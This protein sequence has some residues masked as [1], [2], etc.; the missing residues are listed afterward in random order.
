MKKKL[1][2][3]IVVICTLNLL[4]I[5]ALADESAPQSCGYD[6]Q[7]TQMLKAKGDQRADRA[8]EIIESMLEHATDACVN[9]YGAAACNVQPG[10]KE[11]VANRANPNPSGLDK[12]E[13]T[14]KNV[15][16][17]LPTALPRM[18]KD[19]GRCL[20]VVPSEKT[21]DFL[22][23]FFA[24]LEYG[25]GV[26]FCR[27][28]ENSPFDFSKPTSY[29]QIEGGSFGPNFG[30]GEESDVVLSVSKDDP[31]VRKI[32]A[33]GKLTATAIVGRD[34]E[35]G[36]QIGVDKSHEPAIAVAYSH[37]KGFLFAANIDLK[38]ISPDK[39]M[40]EAESGQIAHERNPLMRWLHM[41]ARKKA[42]AACLQKD[43]NVADVSSEQSPDLE[44]TTMDEVLPEQPL[45]SA[46]ASAMASVSVESNKAVAEAAP[47]A[48]LV[49]GA[50]A[51]HAGS[52]MESQFGNYP[53]IGLNY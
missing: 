34:L 25:R 45:Q 41:G 21:L 53:S 24:G 36:G 43:P 6:Y 30:L 9:E 16:A 49:P 22:V 44:S 20:I 3:S 2:L 39:D 33:A 19:P 52:T 28:D 4:A 40:N 48:S 31:N 1:G 5:S 18:L 29:V 50:P 37:T 17:M 35:V 32:N 46:P 12:F 38:S 8:K 47:A 7:R 51:G 11:D 10:S 42:D 13:R 27:K 26:E 15:D 14:A 23:P